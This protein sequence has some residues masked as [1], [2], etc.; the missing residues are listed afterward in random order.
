MIQKF[1]QSFEDMKQ[2]YA[3]YAYVT[4]VDKYG[5]VTSSQTAQKETIHCMWQVLTNEA[6]IVEYGLD[7][8]S[9]YYCIIYEDKNIDFGDIVTINDELYE[10]V[11]I[12]RFNTHTRIDVKKK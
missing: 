4:V 3:V 9:M 6:D 8:K 12:K 10:V 7:V 5:N 2:D 1:N 11:S